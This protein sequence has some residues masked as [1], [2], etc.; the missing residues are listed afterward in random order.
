I[1]GGLVASKSDTYN[2]YGVESVGTSQVYD[3]HHNVFRATGSLLQ[4]RDGHTATLLHSGLVLV[5]G[6]D[7]NYYRALASAELYDPA[8]GTM[9]DAG[10]MS[11]SRGGHAATLLQDGR[12][13][14]TGGDA[15]GSSELYVPP[16]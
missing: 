12:V 4:A 9:T 11:V 10:G 5:T 1:M 16:A 7:W 14:L 15:I 2:D 6:G 8:C 13:L 3:P